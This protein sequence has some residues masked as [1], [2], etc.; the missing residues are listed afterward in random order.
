[1]T[2]DHW[3]N[4]YYG[5]LLV[6]FVV[7]SSLF[8]AIAGL[9]LDIPVHL[10]HSA[11]H[12]I[13]LRNASSISLLVDL[14]TTLV[15]VLM[16][17]RLIHASFWYSFLRSYCFQV[18]DPVSFAVLSTTFLVNVGVQPGILLL[19]GKPSVCSCVL[20]F[21]QFSFLLSTFSAFFCNF[22]WTPGSPLLPLEAC[23]WSS[24]TLPCLSCFIDLS[25]IHNFLVS[26]LYPSFP[27][28]PMYALG[29]L[30]FYI[31]IDLRTRLLFPFLYSIIATDWSTVNFSVCTCCLVASTDGKAS[32]SMSAGF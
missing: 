6:D 22:L 7:P 4:A 14:E 2:P 9:R 16:L 27:K 29:L 30:L 1:M 32:I 18:T 19:H 10:D 24:N 8:I 12:G 15:R 23:Y 25:C 21:S 20:S 5:A 17:P 28:P 13:Y 3:I 31:V 11:R 26:T